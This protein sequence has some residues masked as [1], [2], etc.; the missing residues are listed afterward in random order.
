MPKF[1]A[2][3]ALKHL[4]GSAAQVDRDLRSFREAAKVLSSNHPRMID[5]HPSR[6][7][8]VYEGTVV[9][10]GRSLKSL[11]SALQKKRIPRDQTIIRFIDR[12]ERTLIL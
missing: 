9:A 3:E 4:G 2:Q 5:E 11:L 1:S 6:W 8:A 12:K 10:T 7:I